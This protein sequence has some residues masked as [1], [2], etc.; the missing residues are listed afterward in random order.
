[1]GHVWWNGIQHDLS[2]ESVTWTKAPTPPVIRTAQSKPLNPHT[3]T[4]G[5]TPD[6]SFK[7]I[8]RRGA[9]VIKVETYP[10]ATEAHAAGE[11]MTRVYGAI[12]LT[13]LA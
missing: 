2:N 3:V 10:T 12:H 5:Q 6:G 1:M 13:A 11:Y 4:S 7:A 8:E 9:S